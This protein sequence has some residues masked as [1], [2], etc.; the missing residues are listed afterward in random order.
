MR[1]RVKRVV[2][3]LLILLVGLGPAA[4]VVAES[5]VCAAGGIVPEGTAHA[6]HSAQQMTQVP[7]VESQGPMNCADCPDDCCA[8]GI[9]AA[10]ACG[11]GAAVL[12]GIAVQQDD[13]ASLDYSAIEP[14]PSLSGLLSP[15]FRPPQA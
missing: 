2:C 10:S 12:H 9:C 6:G 1:S 11:T 7:L 14:N 5:H 4:N 13:I 15:P 3:L 8:N